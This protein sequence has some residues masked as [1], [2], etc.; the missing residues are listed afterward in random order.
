[1]LPVNNAG[2]WCDY[3]ELDLPFAVHYADPEVYVREIIVDWESKGVK[4]QSAGYEFLLPNRVS[5]LVW[6]PWPEHVEDPKLPPIYV[7]QRVRIVGKM[8][9]QPRKT[10]CYEHS[11][12]YSGQWHPVEPVT[13]PSIKALLDET[14]ALYQA[15]DTKKYGTPMCLVNDYTTLHHY[16][17]S[18]GDDDRQMGNLGDVICWVTGAVRKLVIDTKSKPHTK[19]LEF[20][21]LPGLYVMRGRRF[22]KEYRHGIPQELES[23]FKRI[24]TKY[25]PADIPDMLHKSDWLAE[26]YAS[27]MKQ[28]STDDQRLFSQWLDTRN[29]YTIRYFHEKD[30]VCSK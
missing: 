6:I 21:L 9:D 19:L 5:K 12:F 24:A 22:Q 3:T 30:V 2:E 13:P 27:V 17:S 14:T 16:I 11:Y 25:A 15:Y 7:Y 20:D 1:M 26:N 8:V 10:R 4:H 23:F 28:L 18:H 29:S